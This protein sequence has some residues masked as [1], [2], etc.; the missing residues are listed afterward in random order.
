MRYRHK[1]YFTKNPETEF[2]K[3]SNNRLMNI[4]C[5]LFD[6]FLDKYGERKTLQFFKKAHAELEYSKMSNPHFLFPTPQ[7]F[8]EILFQ[9]RVFSTL[10]DEKI[11]IFVEEFFWVNQEGFIDFVPKYDDWI[12]REESM[13]SFLEI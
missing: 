6:L 3:I 4:D 9:P 7:I 12:E 13:K 8:Y 1:Y 2:Y 11:R 5:R 10:S